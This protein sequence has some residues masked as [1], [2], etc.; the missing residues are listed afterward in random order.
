[1]P[2]MLG[3]IQACQWNMEVPEALSCSQ[4]QAAYYWKC[5]WYY[6]IS[7]PLYFFTRV[8]P[9]PAS[10]LLTLSVGPGL[11]ITLVSAAFH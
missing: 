9:F 1:M 11:R 7:T 3:L 2:Q 4:F 8:S 5:I 10:L 6:L